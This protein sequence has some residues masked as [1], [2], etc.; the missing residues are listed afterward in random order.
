MTQKAI[1]CLFMRGGTSR[2][3]FFR[4]SDLPGDPQERA[5]ILLAVVGS[6]DPRQI[7]GLGGGDTL[8][9]KVAMIA[10]SQRDGVD[11]DYLFAQVSV[12]TAYVDTKPSCGN[13]LSGVGPAAIEMGMVQAEDGETR[14]VVYNE[15]TGSRIETII[16]TPGR[17]VRYDGDTEIDGVAGSGAPIVMNFRD[18][19]GSKTGALLPTGD[20][21]E[22]IQGV[23]VSCVDV[24][25][26]MVLM[27]A[28]DFGLTG[29]ESADQVSTDARLRESV[30]SIRREA[31]VRMGLGE[32]CDIVI[33]KVGLLMEPNSGGDIRSWY[34]TPH[35]LHAAHAVTGA[36]CIASAATVD[37]TLAHRFARPSKAN[38]RNFYIEHPTGEISVRL[39]TKNNGGSLDFVAETVRTARLIMRGDVMVPDRLV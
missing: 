27:R 35:T 18:I 6:P 7:N 15:N 8:T 21:T 3:P 22:V 30:E 25:T 9:S 33:P 20:P 29:E 32:V 36:I 34:L 12:E 37:G 38:P 23:E 14:I 11:I 26:P 24:A 16:Q 1:P 13:M 5:R 28:E 31:G 19:V 2:G 39:K 10:P 17:E 4:K